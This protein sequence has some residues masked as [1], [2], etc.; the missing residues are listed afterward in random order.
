MCIVNNYICIRGKKKSLQLN[1]TIILS[2]QHRPK[3]EGKQE[4]KNDITL[5]CLQ[6]KLNWDKN[7]KHISLHD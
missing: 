3:M 7:Y 4:K 5:P 1:Y 6:Q 2:W